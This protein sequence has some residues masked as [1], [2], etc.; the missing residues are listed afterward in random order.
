MF[1][2]L[3]WYSSIAGCDRNA[4]SIFGISVQINA[5]VD[6]VALGRGAVTDGLDDRGVVGV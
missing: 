6:S 2:H 1:D 5:D 3:R 4:M